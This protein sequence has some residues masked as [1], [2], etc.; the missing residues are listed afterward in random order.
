MK[1][2]S[3]IITLLVL[4]A[5]ITAALAATTISDIR[6]KRGPEASLP[7][8]AKSGEPLFT[9]DT[10]RVFIGTSSARVE[11][12]KTTGN[13]RGLT[14]MSSSQV[15]LGNV[16]NTA[17]SAKPVST[18]QQSAL[19]LKANASAVSNVTNE[20][21]A[22]MFTN[23]V[24]T[25]GLTVP[26]IHSSAADGEHS[27][28]IG[29][30]VAYTGTRTKGT[31]FH[32]VTT[33][34]YCEQDNVC[35]RIGTGGA[36]EAVDLADAQNQPYDNTISGLIATTIKTAIDEI[37][38]FVTAQTA[39]LLAALEAAGILAPASMAV[40]KTELV[41]ANTS[42]GGPFR[43]GTWTITA[44][45]F[46][47]LSTHNWTIAGSGA[48]NFKNWSGCSNKTLAPNAT[49]VTTARFQP[50][51]Q[52]T[53]SSVVSMAS[54]DPAATKTIRLQGT[55]VT[56]AGTGSDSFTYSNG[57]L[58]TV[59][60]GKWAYMTG[61]E[62]AIVSSNTVTVSDNSGSNR[63][64]YWVDTALSDDHCSK[65][66]IVTLGS[67]NMSPTV[68]QSATAGTH[69]RWSANAVNAYVNGS[70]NSQV[71]AGLPTLAGGDIVEL[72]A[73]GTTI[74]ALLNGS[75]VGTGTSSVI[76]TGYAGISLHYSNA[77]LDNWEGRTAP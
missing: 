77:F 7:A 42:T 48:A 25:G 43:T 49:C 62:S 2:H 27:I 24:I 64:V 33:I 17:D 55:G 72:C 63:L 28:D 10:H 40:D 15:G 9:T 70:Y 51:V 67:S 38:A 60:S 4:T 68:R 58:V 39:S 53:Y 19:D 65:F 69:Y 12:L 13:G 47:N 56:P 35:K 52:G 1:K 46:R 73:K 61:S 22:T 18:A 37:K 31:I 6:L 26:V 54:N 59:S 29:N 16:N 30:G 36:G 57:N 34:N 75:Q 32:N 76:A 21:K 20:S 41:F 71:F 14:N 45:A 44:G 5:S 50:A 66:T 3:L 23:P 11:L 8:R 74:T